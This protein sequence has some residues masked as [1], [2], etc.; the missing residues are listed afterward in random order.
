MNTDDIIKAVGAAIAE[1][2]GIN[3]EQQLLQ[4]IQSMSD[5]GIQK[6]AD[7]ITTEKDDKKKIKRVQTEVQKDIQTQKTMKAEFG[8]KLKYLQSLRQGSTIKSMRQGGDP[9]S[10]DSTEGMKPN[11]TQ[12]KMLKA[13][14]GMLGMLGNSGGGGMGG[15]MSGISNGVGKVMDGIAA[16]KKSH[17][18][19]NMEEEIQKTNRMNTALYLNFA[20]QQLATQQAALNQ[21][22]PQ[23][24]QFQ[25][26]LT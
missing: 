21:Q 3:D 2:F 23:F 22:M 17:D 11:K 13:A 20:S 15:M 6:I 16:M 19:A 9:G 5:E 4:I 10:I 7:I 12:K 8:A 1:A 18:M 24:K 14:G 26:Y 25:T